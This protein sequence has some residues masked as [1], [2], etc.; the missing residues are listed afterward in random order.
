MEISRWSF[1]GSCRE[2]GTLDYPHN[3]IR[4]LYEVED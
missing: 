3:G 4:E 2:D 1:S